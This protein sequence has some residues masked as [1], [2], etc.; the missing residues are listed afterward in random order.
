MWQGTDKSLVG[1]TEGAR[2]F[3]RYGYA[4]FLDEDRTIDF[5]FRIWPGAEMV[6][7]P[8][9]TFLACR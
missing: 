7:R 3:T 9:P 5:M 8:C 1:V 6:R 2:K 4:D